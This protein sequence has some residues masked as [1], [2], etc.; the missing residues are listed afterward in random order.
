MVELVTVHPLSLLTQH[1]VREGNSAAVPKAETR[2]HPG[3]QGQDATHRRTV[4]LT[5]QV[6]QPG[7]L[8]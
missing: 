4:E 1:V 3:G 8:S 2:V 5:T 7:A 6:E